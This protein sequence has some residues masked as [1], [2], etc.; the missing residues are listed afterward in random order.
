MV[1]CRRHWVILWH[2]G[3]AALGAEGGGCSPSLAS[4]GP[5]ALLGCHTSFVVNPNQ[6][7]CQQLAAGVGQW[8]RSQGTA[9][10]CQAVTTLC[11]PAQNILGLQGIPRQFFL[12]VYET[13]RRI[14]ETRLA[15][16]HPCPA[17]SSA[18]AASWALLLCSPSL[19]SPL[20]LVP[21]SLP[22]TV[23]QAPFPWGFVG[24]LPV[25]AACLGWHR[26]A[27]CRAGDAVLGLTC[28][29]VLTGLRAM[30][31]HLPQAAPAEPLAVRISYL[32]VWI[33][34]TGVS[35]VP[36]PVPSRGLISLGQGRHSPKLVKPRLAGAQT[37]VREDK[38]PSVL[39]LC[40]FLRL[41]SPQQLGSPSPA[42]RPAGLGSG[43]VS[44]LLSPLL[45]H[46]MLLSSCLLAWLLTP[47]R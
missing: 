27:S 38:V 40:P 29:A 43:Q 33:S 6:S 3:F 37:W 5:E 20:G 23:T 31:S 39:P 10:L 8:L 19:W 18:A 26:C 15:P 46:A 44:H 24:A 12:Q 42:F 2:G 7:L 4:Q 28:L 14:G 1:T 30:K 21:R 17:P 25:P 45:Q 32:I 36:C 47:S 35:A 16:S 41:R 11:L 13:L 22:S 34:A 9:G